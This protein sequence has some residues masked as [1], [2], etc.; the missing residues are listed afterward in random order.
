VVR[1]ATLIFE[2]PRRPCRRGKRGLSRVESNKGTSGRQIPK[3]E[4]GLRQEFL[5]PPGTR[6]CILPVPAEGAEGDGDPALQN[7][8]RKM[9]GVPGK[10]TEEVEP[11]FSQAQ[12]RT[13]F[14][15]RRV[16]RRPG[17]ARGVQ[18]RLLVIALRPT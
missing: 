11:G 12:Q 5:V 16:C 8:R 6:R 1:L 7:V 10:Q 15:R 3:G 4:D 13:Q 9:G 17:R 18:D 14:P 2:I